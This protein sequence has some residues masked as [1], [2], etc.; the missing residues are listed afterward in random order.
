MNNNKMIDKLRKHF[1]FYDKSGE[2]LISR[3]ELKNMMNK[4]SE[5]N[6]SEMEINDL[7]DKIDQDNSGSI[8]FEEFLR[9]MIDYNTLLTKENLEI[10]FKIPRT[11]LSFPLAFTIRYNGWLVSYLTIS[12]IS[13]SYKANP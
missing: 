4:I 8:S 6:M 2:G 1:R 11:L 13:S 12:L 9:V 5:K 10:A 7:M 3:E